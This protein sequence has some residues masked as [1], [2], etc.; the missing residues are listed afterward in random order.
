VDRRVST[1]FES[2]KYPCHMVSLV[3]DNQLLKSLNIL[4]EKFKWWGSLD[5]L[6]VGAVGEFRDHAS[7]V[8]ECLIVGG[9]SLVFLFDS[10]VVEPSHVRSDDPVMRW[11]DHDV[12]FFCCECER[13]RIVE[14]IHLESSGDCLGRCW[15]DADRVV[16]DFIE[17]GACWDTRCELGVIFLLRGSRE[18]ISEVIPTIISILESHLCDFIYRRAEV[19]IVSASI[20]GIL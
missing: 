5:D 1:A 15:V 17:W 19:C 8:Y 6:T 14:S 10:F 20:K 9:R 13:D 18:Y 12:R 4:G 2:Q 11:R 7:L 16:R 3:S